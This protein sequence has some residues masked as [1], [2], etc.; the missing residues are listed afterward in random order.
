MQGINRKNLMISIL[1]S[2]IL[3]FAI[4]ILLFKYLSLPREEF[5]LYSSQNLAAGIMQAAAFSILLIIV[6]VA[7]TVIIPKEKLDD[8]I[9]NILISYLSYPELAV[10][11]LL[12]SICE[13]LLFR[14]VIQSY[15]GI[16][17]TS[18]IFTLAHYRYFAKPYLMIQVLI[19][20]AVLGYAYKL[21]G[22]FLVVVA[23][24]FLVNF[25]N[26][27]LEKTGFLEKLSKG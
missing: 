15:L 19:M 23:I 17:L 4:G 2:N 21:S 1:A 12:G 10:V 9:N 18:L 11:F 13:E 20:G 8:E 5:V 22:V 24:H 27:V 3:I 26:V 16:I 25:I 14:A 6:V 7:F